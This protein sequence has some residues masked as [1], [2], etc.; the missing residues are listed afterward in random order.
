MDSARQHG[1]Q[2]FEVQHSGS[3]VTFGR[4]G[5][6]TDPEVAHWFAKLAAYAPAPAFVRDSEGRYLWVNA[7]YAHLYRTEPDAIAGRSVEE[8]DPP[9]DAALFRAL[10][11]DVLRTRRPVRHTLAFVHPDGTPGQ[12]V[13]HRFALESRGGPCVGGIY[14]DV[15]GRTRALEEKAAVDEEMHALRERTGLAVV[16]VD[17]DGRVEEASGGAA[18][19][20]GSSRGALEGTAALDHLDGGLGRSALIR[21]W[22]DLVGGR[23]ARCSE[24]LRLRMAG[25][26]GRLL[27]ADLAAVRSGGI[28]E[29]IIAVLTPLGAET[30]E[31][32]Q[33]SP[34]Q[35]RVLTLMAGGQP[36]SGMATR[37]GLSRQALDYHL[38]RLRELLD[39]ASRPEMVARAYAL[40]IL[41]ATTWPPRATPGILHG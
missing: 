7:A 30:A 26:G 41:D 1:L 10:D 36:N 16:T 24:V 20:L 15:T 19:L 9:G 40:G 2:D 29:R 5:L 13:G 6:G 18:Q 32:T 31:K 28:T 11:R 8:I 37:L 35:L 14:A 34:L 23:T 27:R 25:G 17:P 39:A 21:S 4:S 12:V 22:M 38:R 33:V 3:D